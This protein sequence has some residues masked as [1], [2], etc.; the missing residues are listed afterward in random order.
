MKKDKQFPEGLLWGGATSAYQFEGAWNEDGKGVTLWIFFHMAAE[1][2]YQRIIRFCRMYFILPM[3]V[4]I[5]ITPIRRISDCLR[6]W[7]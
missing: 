2:R 1:R 4:L 6:R 7:V 3:A 5:S